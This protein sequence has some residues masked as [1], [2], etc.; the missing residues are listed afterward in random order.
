[1]QKLHEYCNPRQNEVLETYR[2]WNLT[3]VS[4]Y[5]LFITKL[6]TQAEKC[7][8]KDKDR[9]IRDKL[10]FTAGKELQERLLLCKELTLQK[11]IEICQAYE[12]TQNCLTEMTN[13]SCTAEVH[14]LE[15]RKSSELKKYTI[16]CRFC[17]GKHE[18]N[19]LIC[20]AW[21]QT[22][23]ICQKMNHFEV[24]CKTQKLDYMGSALKQGPCINLLNTMK[25]KEDHRLHVAEGKQLTVDLQNVAVDSQNVDSVDGITNL[26]RQLVQHG[27]K[28]AIRA[29]N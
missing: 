24:K 5:D 18:Y 26:R 10:V 17:G 14:G 6:R 7:N 12:Q 20:P 27:E 23:N 9:M 8:F 16:D 22:C 1:M 25:S 15:E 19:R 4:S 11:A 13:E 28:N 21:G 29:I 2:F 3:R